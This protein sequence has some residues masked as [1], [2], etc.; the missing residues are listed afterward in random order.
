LKIGAALSG[1]FFLCVVLA[2]L[3]QTESIQAFSVDVRLRKSLDRADEILAQLKEASIANAKTNYMTLAW[4]NRFD[5]PKAIEKQSIIAAIDKQLADLKVGQDQRRELSHTFVRL[6]GLD[7]HFVYKNVMYR[8]VQA[9][10]HRLPPLVPAAPN[11]E[12][13]TL[14]KNQAEWNAE[15]SRPYTLESFELREQLKL[16]TPKTMMSDDEISKA[17]AFADQIISMYVA[18]QSEANYS[19]EAAE[20]IDKSREPTGIN[21]KT[22]ELFGYTFE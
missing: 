1:L 22:R 14:S 21:D 4:G 20:L 6:I 3:P 10:E 16:T 12:R 15:I 2:Y 9:K 8:L 17:N 5:G 19:K 11:Q 13:V 18:S 7:L